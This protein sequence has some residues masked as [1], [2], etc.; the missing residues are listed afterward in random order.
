MIDSTQRERLPRE[1]SARRIDVLFFLYNLAG[2]GLEKKFLRLAT[3]LSE[4]GRHIGIAVCV[5]EGDLAERVAD[6]ISVIELES[7]PM[8]RARY[9]ALQADLSALPALMRPMLLT[10]KP[11]RVLRFLPSLAQLLQRQSPRSLFTAMPHNNIVAVLA[12]RLS[13]ANTR[14]VLSEINSV[15]DKLESSREWMSRFVQPLMSREYGR[16]DAIIAVSDGVATDLAA[17][18][19]LARDRITTVYNPTVTPEIFEKAKEPLNHP[20]FGPGEPPVILGVGRYHPNKDFPSLIRAF[21]KVRTDRPVR[22]VILGD[23]ATGKKRDRYIGD[24]DALV[25]D[26][27]IKDDIDF[28][29]FTIN[30]YRYMSRAGVFVL[31]SLREGFPNVLVEAMASGCPVVATNCPHGPPEI[32]ANGTFGRIVPMRDVDKMAEAISQTLDAPIPAERMRERALEFTAD[33][34][35]ERY[36]RILLNGSHR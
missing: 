13:G 20:W 12:Q 14:I 21:A 33:R 18:T 27:G 24:I 6:S 4:R 35:L 31:S 29:G 22:L 5:R 25:A 1:P 15:R 10:R 16:A 3:M 9:A 8:W 19:G 7:V 23:A 2:G 34:A 32:L 28:P 36:E 26:L 30:P 17:F 11:P